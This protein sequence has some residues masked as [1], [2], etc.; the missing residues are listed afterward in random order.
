M[1]E[2]FRKHHYILMLVIAILVCVAFVFFSDGST[3]GSVNASKPLF[4]LDGADYFQNEV[5]QIDSQRSLIARVT[6]DPGNQM[7]MFSG[8]LAFYVNTLGGNSMI[9]RP[10]IAQRFG[11]SGRDSFNMDF[12][13]NVATLR[14]EAKKLGVDVEREDLEKFVQTIAGFQTNGQFDSTKYQAFLSSGAFGD[15][16]NTER[17]LFTTLRDV[18]VF[19][20]MNK[21]IGG[22]FAPSAVEIDAGY[23]ESKQQT[24]AAYALIEKAKQT[25]AAPTDEAVQK[26][27]DDAKATFAAHAADSAKPAADPSVLSEDKRSVRYVLINL[28]KAPEALPSPQPENTAD[29]PEDQKKA[30]EEEFKKKL[31]E[32]TAA[33][34]KRAEDMKTFEADKKNLLAKANEISTKLSA[35]DR[36]QTTFDDIVKAASLEPKLSPVFTA[37]LPPDDLKAEAALLKEIFNSPNDPTIPH[38]LQTANG[39]ALFEIASVEAPALLPLDQIK[40][41]IIEK[42]TAEALTAAVKTAADTARTALLE[43]MKAG[44]TFAEAAT[45]A[46]LAAVEVPAFTKQKPPTVPNAAVITEATA[47]VNPGE[48]SEAKEVPEGLILVSTIKRGLPKDPKM[49]EEKKTL[50]KQR[51][52]GAEGGFLPTYSPLFEA[53]FQAKRNETSAVKTD[54]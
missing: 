42:L 4:T 1:L 38:T 9:G 48:V 3:P 43:S 23:A 25:P 12:C 32:H 52:E 36:G 29:L 26:F 7:S 40:P 53:W 41:K 28:P 14:A 51:T 31:D 21:L 33:M 44:K 16:S 6:Y 54:S 17:R 5:S 20:R 13:M 47:S 22:T 39:Y 45:A 27:H 15:K 49:D 50:T 18:M 35:D 30:K 8:P 24:T 46:G 37:A 2:T 34:A 19:E 11:Q 10:A